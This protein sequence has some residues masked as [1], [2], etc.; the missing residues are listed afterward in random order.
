M[1]AA[2]CYDSIA[3][4]IVSLIYQAFGCPLSAVELMLGAIQEMK[5]LL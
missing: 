3:H 5:Y 4:A 1:D 2:N